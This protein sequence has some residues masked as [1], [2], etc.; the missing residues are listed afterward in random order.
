[1]AERSEHLDANIREAITT[2]KLEPG[3][4][5]MMDTI[6]KNGFKLIGA[7]D[8]MFAYPLWLAATSVS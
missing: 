2:A 6:Q 1:M 8:N 7:T 5:K 3:P 4:A